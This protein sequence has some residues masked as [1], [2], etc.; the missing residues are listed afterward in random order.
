MPD[1]PLAA[2]RYVSFT[3][4]RRDGR[5]VATPVWIA[6]LGDGRLGFT[7]DAD[8]GKVKR[9]R[10][11]PAVTLRPCT[12]RGR[13]DPHAPEVR[14]TATIVTG[15]AK[16]EVW[17]AVRRKYRVVAPLFD[18]GA[19]LGRLVRRPQSP[20]CAIVIS[21]DPVTRPPD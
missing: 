15:S 20:G 14:G 6:A 19:A 21:L 16:D 12:V 7:S 5:G 8:A 9:L 4:F 10:N 18:I 13:V 3:T 11:N 1:D 2:A 17:R